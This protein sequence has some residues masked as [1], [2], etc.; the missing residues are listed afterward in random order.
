MTSLQDHLIFAPHHRKSIASSCKSDD[1]HS[2]DSTSSASNHL[3]SAS[4][5]TCNEVIEAQSSSPMFPPADTDGGC[6]QP[7]AGSNHKTADSGSCA[8]CASL[9]KR[10]ARLETQSEIATEL[11]AKIIPRLTQENVAT[12]ST[13]RN[14]AITPVTNPHGYSSRG[15]APP[16]FDDFQE[17]YDFLKADL[18]RQNRV[19]DQVEERMKLFVEPVATL[20]RDVDS[21]Y[22]WQQSVVDAE[23]HRL[24]EEA[25][26]KP[27]KVPR[28]SYTDRWKV[29]FRPEASAAEPSTTLD[30]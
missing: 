10:I 26:A 2:H 27:E 15:E 11:F 14:A 5:P 29:D 25:K 22:A 23:D 18:A 7:S 13:G 19:I 6:Q 17:L 20:R 28:K 9:M 21:L 24:Q 8:N 1:T 4:K 3:E 30:T 12:P 16:T